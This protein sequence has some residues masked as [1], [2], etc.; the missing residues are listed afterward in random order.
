MKS[1]QDDAGVD[2]GV[3]TVAKSVGEV[4]C[5]QPGYRMRGRADC[6]RALMQCMSARWAEGSG[7]MTECSNAVGYAGVVLWTGYSGCQSRVRLCRGCICV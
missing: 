7:K 4:L 3:L 5:L 1:V 2:G 6:F